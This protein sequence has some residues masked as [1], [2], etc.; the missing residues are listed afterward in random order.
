[1][2]KVTAG[3]E[4][5]VGAK[6]GAEDGGEAKVSRNEYKYEWEGKGELTR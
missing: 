3:G 6:N 1:M 2:K 5:Q 4:K